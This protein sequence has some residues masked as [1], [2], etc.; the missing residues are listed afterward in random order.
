[1]DCGTST[2]NVSYIFSVGNSVLTLP[3]NPTDIV[4]GNQHWGH[5]TSKD[6]YHWENQKIAI[7]PTDENEQI[8]S[9]SAVVDV[10][11]TSGF[12]PEQT[13]GVVAIYTLNTKEAQV[14]DIAYS[15]DG[16]YTFE[17]YSGN[18]VLTHDSTQ[19]RDP[20]VI[21]SHDRWVMVVAFAQE[22]TI[23]IYNSPDLKSW[24]FASNFTP[25]GLIG[26]QYE[27]P[28]LIQIPVAN[29]NDAMYVLAISINPGA[30]QGGS[31]Q[32]YFPGT[33]NGTHFTPVDPVARIADFG[34]D[35]Y[36]GQFFHGLPGTQD[37][38]MIGWASNWQY[39][40][41]VPTGQY[42]NWRSAMT[43]PRSTRLANV[44]R[45]G[46][47]LISYPYDL[48]PILDTQ[49]AYNASL[50]NGSLTTNYADVACGSG[51]VYIQANVS[52]IPA[53]ALATGTLNFTIWS[54]TTKEAI[55][56]GFFFGGDTPFFLSRRNIRGFGDENPFFTDR[57]ST[58][59]IINSDGT[60]TLEV[61]VD[62]TIA[63][64]F[65]DGGRSSGTMTFYPEGML[66]SLEVAA[67]DVNE[68]VVISVGVWALKSAWKDAEDASGV[69]VGNV[70]EAGGL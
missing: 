60:F 30:P 23:G 47:D 50:G 33:F 24:T 44:T 25:H 41:A 40:Q 21:W 52:H 57:F 13:N 36:A 49:L 10:N 59:N 7:F 37:P 31:I 63:E 6:L 55:S 3:D 12:F 51:A 19:F 4:A 39:G 64:V 8:F 29:S 18:P 46:W 15:I 65:L 20:Y 43:V 58:N 14:Q 68:G 1:M 42:E 22:F 32:E 70:T 26:L 11:N 69:V 27:C 66:D 2:I 61:I 34:K 48:S 16:G 38:V 45:I 17:K 62:R 35:N 53:N 28:N 9:G 54:S 5:A 56:G 67:G